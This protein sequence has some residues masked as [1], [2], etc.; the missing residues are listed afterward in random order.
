MTLQSATEMKWTGLRLLFLP[1]KQA[2]HCRPNGFRL[3]SGR[4]WAVS[5][6]L[7]LCQ[8]QNDLGA[9]LQP[10]RP[11]VQRQVMFWPCPTPG[12]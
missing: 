6:S 1:S 12:R 4:P 5:F 7:S 11:A 10:Q 3:M 2:L 9:A 8:V